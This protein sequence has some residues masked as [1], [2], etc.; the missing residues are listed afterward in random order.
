MMKKSK[1]FKLSDFDHHSMKSSSTS[2]LIIKQV[3]ICHPGKPPTQHKQPTTIK[4]GY[5]SP[6]YM[7]STSCF[8]ARK[9]Q[10]SQVS[11]RNSSTSKV[12]SS[13]SNN[14]KPGKT[15][16]KALSS[17]SKLVRTLTK[18]PS[19]KHSRSTS[20]K[21]KS[22]RV[23]LCTAEDDVN[24]ERPTCSSTLK[25]SKFPTHL[26][27]APGGTESD[28]TSIMKVCPYTYCSL[29]GHLHTPLPPLKCFL[30]ARRRS[31]KTQKNMK[32]Q[33][34]SPR[35]ERKLPSEEEVSIE[36]KEAAENV[37]I[38][39]FIEIYP[40]TMEDDVEKNDFVLACSK[41]G[42]EEAAKGEVEARDGYF[43]EQVVEILSDGSPQ[44]EIDTDESL[45]M[46]E[47][48]SEGG[49]YYE[50][51]DYSSMSEHEETEEI[52]SSENAS[53]ITDMEWEEGKFSDA[54]LEDDADNSS[55]IITTCDVNMI[56]DYE[57]DV[58]KEKT[59]CFEVL[60]E[61]NVTEQDM[62]IQEFGTE[63]SDQL[64]YTDEVYKDLY[65]KE[66]TFGEGGDPD[67]MHNN[68][69]MAAT[70]TMRLKADEAE[71]MINHD[72]LTDKDSCDNPKDESK[73]EETKGGKNGIHKTEKESDLL[74]EQQVFDEI[75]T[76]DSPTEHIEERIKSG[77][78]E[79]DIDENQN[80]QLKS[81]NEYEDQWQKNSP[82]REEGDKNE[83]A[84]MEMENKTEQQKKKSST[85]FSRLGQ[86]KDEQEELRNLC[87]R[88]R[89]GVKD[90]E[91]ETTREFNPK[92]PNYLPVVADPEREKVH[93]KH[94][95]MD[96]S[97]NSEQWMID[98]ALQQAVTKL[99]PARKR[100]VALLVEAFEAVTPERRHHHHH[101]HPTSPM[102]EVKN[103]AQEIPKQEIEPLYSIFLA[104]F[105][106]DADSRATDADSI[107]AADT[108]MTIAAGN[109]S[110][111]G[112][113][114]ML[115][116]CE[117]AKVV[118]SGACC[119]RPVGVIV[120][121]EAYVPVLT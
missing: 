38:D 95:M 6:N 19:F 52:Y 15:S 31:L 114:L 78:L 66:E 63:D 53:E 2:T 70:S 97:K 74:E 28:G 25:D 86:L 115:L 20:A 8:D 68:I 76:L 101:R 65:E 87:T 39:F 42:T 71:K 33:V 80:T 3:N 85:T 120:D 107:T 110:V 43:E 7:K 93:L 57:L 12:V 82:E 11:L 102:I 56:H 47:I 9:E 61:E 89:R 113:A 121:A 34:L 30:S 64:S 103:I 54:D 94:Q 67:S 79:Q 27:L 24:V 98:Y 118:R 60:A 111:D 62:E 100:K 92:E 14:K 13:V 50:D 44:S 72:E 16:N 106:T 32:I 55:K 99:A 91:V 81:F 83:N 116:S 1:S 48:F 59:E 119:V 35:K 77:K 40:M 88:S 29:N 58:G 10:Q 90:L 17:S 69:F 41:G 4:T 51:R 84:T 21:R 73:E 96:E 75:S 117:G 18:T 22:S 104:N 46:A 5:G 37:G 23:A 45:G 109:K 105:G 26:T 108:G 112:G 49:N 36:N